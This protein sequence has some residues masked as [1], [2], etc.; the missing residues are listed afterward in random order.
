MPASK[1]Q[2]NRF[3]RVLFCV[4]LILGSVLV[5]IRIGAFV[6]LWFVHHR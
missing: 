3:E 4:A 2:M 6:T 5:A 1:W